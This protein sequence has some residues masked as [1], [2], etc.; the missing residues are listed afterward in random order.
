MP[1]QDAQRATVIQAV[2]VTTDSSGNFT[3]TWPAPF[4][5]PPTGRSATIDLASASGAP[6][7]CSF[8][9]GTVTAI[10]FSGRCFQIVATTLPTTLTALQGLAVSP[11]ANAAGGLTVR[12]TGRQ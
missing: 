9:A 12:V 4:N 8:I 2:P 5:G 11:L 1:R 6:Y 7:T 3:G 10:G